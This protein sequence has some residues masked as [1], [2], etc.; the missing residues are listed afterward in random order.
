M[1]D[2]RHTADYDPLFRAKKSDAVI[3]VRQARAAF[4]QLQHAESSERDAFL[5]LLLFR[6]RG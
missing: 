2:K 5:L 3:A 6:P 4:T 1:Q